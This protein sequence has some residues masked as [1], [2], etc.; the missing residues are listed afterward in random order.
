MRD[1]RPVDELSIEELERVLAIR[2]R[3][4][5]EKRLRRMRESGRVIASPAAA[6]PA[7]GSSGTNGAHPAPAASREGTR[8]VSPVAPLVTPPP[9]VEAPAP[10]PLT[11]LP[12]F[13]DDGYSEEVGLPAVASAPPENPEHA[14]RAFNRLLLLVEVAAVLG[15]IFL[16]VNMLMEINTLQRETA[17]TQRQANAQ[18]LASLATPEPT[19]IISLR[20]EDYVLPGGH[21]VDASGRYQFNTREFEQYVPAHLRGQL[22]DQVVLP[23]SYRRPQITPEDAERIIIEKLGLDESIVP[24]TDEDALRQGVGRVLNGAQPGS[25]TGNLALAAHNDVYGELFRNIPNLAEGDRI[26]VQTR[27]RTYEYEVIGYRIVNPNDVYVLEDQ[28]YA[29]LT[30]ITCHPPGINDKRYVVFA[31]RLTDQGF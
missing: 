12:Q 29:S 8:P 15:L 27:T 1:K 17:E 13:E 6:P 28:G 31:R 2:K 9:T 30:L 20:L 4:E 16:G 7:N 5:R 21:I 11:T 10:P 24:G 23:V 25:P 18:R 3:E 14:R 19:S 26:Y 22:Y